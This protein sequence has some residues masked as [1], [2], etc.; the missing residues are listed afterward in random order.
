MPTLVDVGGGSV[1]NRTR[2]SLARIPLRWMIREC[3]RS[4]CGIQFEAGRLR[5][6]GLD[7]RTLYPKVLDRPAPFSISSLKVVEQEKRDKKID[8]RYELEL[9]CDRCHVYRRPCKSGGSDD[10]T[11]TE[12][13]LHENLH[14]PI[15]LEEHEEL[16]DAVQPIFDQLAKKPVWWMLEWIP[17]VHRVEKADGISTKVV[18]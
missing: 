15:G 3:F 7:P 16:H 13:T 4:E 6:V 1:P 9:V 14:P 2:H 17:L 11:A 12:N 5:D 10:G 18:S 8:G